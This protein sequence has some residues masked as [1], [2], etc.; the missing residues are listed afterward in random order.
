[1]RNK[2]TTLGTVRVPEDIDAKQLKRSLAKDG[3]QVVQ[4]EFHHDPIT[5]KRTGEGFVHVRAG[6]NKKLNEATDLLKMTGIKLDKQ[7]KPREEKRT[8]RWRG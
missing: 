1:M 2:G 6:N 5:N 8:R 7:V 3:Y 4:A